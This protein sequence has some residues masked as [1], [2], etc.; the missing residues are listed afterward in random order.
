MIQHYTSTFGYEVK[1]DLNVFYD[2]G[3]VIGIVTI[4]GHE[5]RFEYQEDDIDQNDEDQLKDAFNMRF[6]NEIAD[7]AQWCCDEYDLENRDDVMLN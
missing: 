2:N 3:K 6:E 5:K 7:F 4:L 1:A